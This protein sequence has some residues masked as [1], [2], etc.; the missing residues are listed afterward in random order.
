MDHLVAASFCWGAAEATV[1]FVIPDVLTC[2]AA[3]TDPRR[4]PRAY[5]AAVVGALAGSAVLHTASRPLGA[6]LE[7]LFASLPGISAADIEDARRTVERRGPAALVQLPLN[8]QP[9]KLYVY[10]AALLG[11][12]AGKVLPYVALNRLARLGSSATAAAATG[13]LL[14]GQIERHPSLTRLAYV[15]GW[16]AFYAVY[17]ARRRR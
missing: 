2:Y 6:Q 11:S 16:A 10:S 7:G 15:G 3:L 17:W 9:I 4:M 12:P 14:R 5:L 1:F 8:G 13:W